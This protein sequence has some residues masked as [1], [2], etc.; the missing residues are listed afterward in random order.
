M[1]EIPNTVFVC[2]FYFLWDMMRTV[3]GGLVSDNLELD[4]AGK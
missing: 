1:L 3:G 2:D 4:T